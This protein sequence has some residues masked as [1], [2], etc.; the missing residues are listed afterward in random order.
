MME[1]AL[2]G[3]KFVLASVVEDTPE[4]AEVQLAR[5]EFLEGKVIND[6]AD[7]DDDDDGGLGDNDNGFSL[8]VQWRGPDLL[9]RGD[10]KDQ[11][12]LA[13]C[14][15]PIHIL[16]AFEQQVTDLLANVLSIVSTGLWFGRLLV[17]KLAVCCI[18]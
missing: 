12:V 4:F 5:V 10:A 13:C 17:A 15:P 2:F 11:R 6:I 1:H 3:V 9:K 8:L 16:A 18:F 14:S 7:E